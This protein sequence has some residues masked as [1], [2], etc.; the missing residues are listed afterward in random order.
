MARP[1]IV[2]HYTS[3]DLW[4][5]KIS[6]EGLVP[7]PIDRVHL[8]RYFEEC[9]LEPK[10]I[11]VWPNIT[12]S[13]LRDFY[14]FNYADKSYDR[15][16]ILKCYI[17]EENLLTRCW[18]EKDTLTLYHP[19]TF[20]II[21]DQKEINKLKH[22]APFDIVIKPI[23]PKYITPIYKIGIRVEKLKEE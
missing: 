13:L 4:K 15:G 10:G 14:I 16:I 1:K 20:S 8:L 22:D 6:K 17:K 12:N 19:L 21:K 23:K 2:Y 3:L 18:S 11:W 9:R 5:K 7:Q